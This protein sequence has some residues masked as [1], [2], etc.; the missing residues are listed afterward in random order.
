MEK[1]EANFMTIM[2]QA[3]MTSDEFLR[4]AIK[5]IDAR[6]GAGYAAK[7]PQLIGAMVMASAIDEGCTVMAKT[8]PDGLEG[9][10]EGLKLVSE[11]LNSIATAIYQKD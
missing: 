9:I 3:S 11:S 10:Y 7:N 4:E 5:N 1:I 6:L 8:I 2:R